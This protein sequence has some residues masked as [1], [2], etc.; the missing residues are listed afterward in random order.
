MLSRHASDSVR[1]LPSRSRRASGGS[2][3]LKPVAQTIVSTSRSL[4]SANASEFARI[5]VS[6][7]VT[8]SAFGSWSAGYQS[9][10]SST[11]LQPSLY[12]GTSLRSE[13]HTSELQSRQYLVCRLLLEKKKNTSYKVIA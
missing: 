2:V 11:R 7:S 8:S 13:E 3:G 5:S 12:G 6:P 10:E 1:P 9:S 4:P